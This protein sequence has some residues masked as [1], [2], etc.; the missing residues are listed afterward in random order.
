V[1]LAGTAV[2]AMMFTMSRPPPPVT[3]AGVLTPVALHDTTAQD[4]IAKRLLRVIAQHP[5]SIASRLSTA[6]E[7]GPASDAYMNFWMMQMGAASISDP[8]R[9]SAYSMDSTDPAA[10]CFAIAS[11][12]GGVTVWTR[13]PGLREELA[14][15]CD[16]AYDY[17]VLVLPGGAG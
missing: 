4:A 17:R 1:L 6:A 16:P 8:I 5:K 7:G 10:V 15:P 2:F 14:K 3:V 11:W 12:G 13:D 9:N